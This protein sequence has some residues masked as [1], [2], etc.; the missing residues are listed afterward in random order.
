MLTISR[1]TIKKYIDGNQIPWERSGKNGRT[2]YVVTSASE[3]IIKEQTEDDKEKFKNELLTPTRFIRG[4][5]MRI[6]LSPFFIQI[7]T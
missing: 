4:L 3:D 2:P 5:L 7:Y 1:T 6:L